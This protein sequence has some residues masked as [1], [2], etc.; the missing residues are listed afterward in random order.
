M[1]TLRDQVL[2]RKDEHPIVTQ[3]ECILKT[4]VFDTSRFEG[5][6]YLD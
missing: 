4:K 6:I 2:L 5:V 1:K 3:T